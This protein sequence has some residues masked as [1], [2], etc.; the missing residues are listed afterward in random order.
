MEALLSSQI[1]PLRTHWK[2]RRPPSLPAFTLKSTETL[3]RKRVGMVNAEPFNSV[4]VS[5]QAVQAETFGRFDNTLP[6]KGMVSS[7]SNQQKR[8]ESW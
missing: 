7:V 4:S 8:I 2:Q 3:Q 1:I 5:V 6:T